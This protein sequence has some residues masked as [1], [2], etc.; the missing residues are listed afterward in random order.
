MKREMF[1]KLMAASLATVMVAGLAGCGNDDNASSG[2]PSS[3]QP[4]GSSNV[5]DNNSGEPSGDGDVSPYPIMKDANGNKYDLGG[6]EVYIYTWFGEG[7]VDSPYT[8]ALNEYRE[9][10]QK[11]YNFTMTWDNSGSWGSFN[12]FADLASG[13]KDTEGKLR[14]YMLPAQQTP[15]YTAMTQGLMWNLSSLLPEGT[16]NE[17]RFTQNGVSD[18]YQIN[19]DVYACSAQSPEPRTGVWFNATLLEQLTGI[20]ADDMYDLQAKGEWT[21]AKFEEICE[22]IY[23]NGDVNSDGVQD[24]Y[25][26]TG[27]VGG[28]IRA[29][30]RCNGTDFVKLGDDGKLVYLVDSP[31]TQ[32]ALEFQHRVRKAPYWYNNPVTGEDAAWDYFFAAFD[33][34]GKF[35]FMPEQAYLCNENQRLNQ[36][37]LPNAG[38]Y[39][40]LMFPIGPSAG[41]KY[42]NT[43]EDN[44]MAIPKCYTEDEART[45]A[46]AYSIWFADVI[47][48]YIG[49]NSRLDGYESA[50]VHERALTET[51]TRMMS[52]GAYVDTGFMTGKNFTNDPD[53]NNAD[54]WDTSKSVAE[55][56]AAYE[57][58]WKTAIDDFNN[59]Q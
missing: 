19:G 4:E 46:A 58:V 54:I 15:V 43:Y 45:I 10:A 25:A 44:I 35:V 52:E 37:E 31:A 12:D 30:V 17:R 55:C 8:D 49:Y 24:Y 57:S 28:F 16:F 23:Q 56:M 14:F 3:N 18:L 40:F 7:N 39:G 26:V 59:K 27:N 38:E 20:T 53:K 33:E 41:G 9:W 11:E 34:E 29:A 22:K 32:E 36:N 50:L 6:A 1:R 51:M 47:P 2:T 48:G 5:A 21:Y 13:A 42:V